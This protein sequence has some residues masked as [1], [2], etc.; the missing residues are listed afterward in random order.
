MR[1]NRKRSGKNKMRF[2][3]RNIFF[4]LIGICCI[5]MFVSLTFNING[6]PLKNVA[7]YVFG[8]M[9]RGLNQIGQVLT[10]RKD[11]LKN[12]SK[13]VAENER[14]HKQIDELTTENS[15]LKLKQYELENLQKLYELDQKYPSYKKTGARVIA[16]DAGNWFDSFVID[17]GSKDGIEVDMNVIAGS[18][19]VGRVTAVGRHSATVTSIINDTCN[20]SGMMIST[21]DYC[22]IRGNL[23]TMNQDQVIPFDTLK[24]PKDKVTEGEQVVTSNISDK[25][26]E[27]ILVGY[28]TTIKTDS[29]NLT[30]SGTITPV[31]DFEHL[32]EV[33]VIMEK[34]EYN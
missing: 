29:N 9:Q 7:D 13:V 17:K 4:T 18:G 8:P 19:L 15:T 26:L 3:T 14:L 24:D 33:L 25:Y 11:E 21:S 20:F 31:V 12:L 1:R 5:S 28:V 6:G 16:K 32:E 2:S 30:K 23:M 22:I 27:G 10:N 34:K